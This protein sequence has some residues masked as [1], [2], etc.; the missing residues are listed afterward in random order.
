MSDLRQRLDKRDS[1]LKQQAIQAFQNHVIRKREGERCFLLQSPH[2]DGGWEGNMA[3]EIFLGFMSYIY[4]GGDIDGLIFGHGP[5]NIRQRIAW[6]GGT[7]DVS[8]YVR[9]KAAIGMS[10]RGVIDTWDSDLAVA[11]VRSYLADFHGEEY[12]DLREAVEDV[13][14]N[15]P[16]CYEE[17][18]QNLSDAIPSSHNSFLDDFGAVGY[19]TSHR[20]YCCWGAIRRLH[21]LLYEEEKG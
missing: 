4:V 11:E 3:A 2:K 8:Y 20:V 13:L 10:G 15:R 5:Q 7:E 9:Q 1:E 18:Y 12:A 6:M 16:G 17:L 21:L 19:V 14:S